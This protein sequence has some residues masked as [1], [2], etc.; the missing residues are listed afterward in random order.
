MNS[1][2]VLISD[3]PDGLRAAAVLGRL[4]VPVQLLQ[5][6]STPSGLR[7][8]SIPVEPPR[9]AVP[10]SVASLLASAVGPLAPATAPVR[11]L[12]TPMGKAPLPASLR[13]LSRLVDRALLPDLVREY[14]R[15]RGRN[16]LAELV[17]G[18]QE[19]RSHRD[20]V[21]RRMGAP[22]WSTLYAPYIQ[23]RDGAPS[24]DLSSVRARVLHA[25]PPLRRGVHLCRPDD[26]EAQAVAAVQA[27]GGSV[28][29]GVTVNRLE[30]E[31]GV[32]D[33]AVLSDGRRVALG[34]RLWT[35][36]SHR[37][38]VSWLGD[39][40]P[41]AL[42]ID[43]RRLPGRAALRVFLPGTLEAVGGRPVEEIHVVD[44]AFPLWRVVQVDGGVVASITEPEGTPISDP[45][46]RDECALRLSQRGLAQ[47]DVAGARVERLRDWE[48]VW[49]RNA[50]AVLRPVQLGWTALGITTVG[51]A[52]THAPL[53]VGEE[54][55]VVHALAAEQLD[56][57]EVQRRLVYA[58]ARLDDLW[59]DPGAFVGR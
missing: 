59:A 45:V 3:G 18:G 46:V 20:W 15:T 51:R 55:A 32:I 41:D 23:A 30:L 56:L 35:T 27:A 19:E 16:G 57:Q 39:H 33:A 29:C 11:A 44:H 54:A 2:R 47:V 10:A 42:S 14:T 49:V 37:R 34:G 31:A 40:A 4:G 12:S 7:A 22:L 21:V 53:G 50:H 25:S 38:L 9:F 8:A 6:G 24:S 58:P 26:W 17:G 48:P 43:A 13:A 1:P 28:E 52:G 5:S 36:V